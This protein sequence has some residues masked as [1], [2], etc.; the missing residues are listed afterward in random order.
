MPGDGD[1]GGGALGVD[2]DGP[3]GG[4][5]SGAVGVEDPGPAGGGTS[6]AVGTG[7]GTVGGH[8]S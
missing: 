3:A 7:G 6:G 4:G 5:A 8:Q 2:I 1:E